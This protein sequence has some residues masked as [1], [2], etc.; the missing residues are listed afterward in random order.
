MASDHDLHE[1]DLERLLPTALRDGLSP[2]PDPSTLAAGGLAVAGHVAACERCQAVVFA[3]MAPSVPPPEPGRWRA[4]LARGRTVFRARPSDLLHIVIRLIDDAL[5][6]VH[7]TGAAPAAASVRS[8]ESAG[9]FVSQQV[10][11]WDVHTHT[12]YSRGGDFAILLDMTLHDADMRDP[13]VGRRGAGLSWGEPRV[14]LL[15]G[16]RELASHVAQR[17]RVLLAGVRPGT[18]RLQLAAGDRAIGG[19][20]VD[21]QTV[22]LQT[23]D[24]QT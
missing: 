8:A 20:T 7:T 24:L 11:A 14:T 6:L 5:E 3:A 22:D 12:S 1:R 15:R 18:Y 16:E 23:V 9:V 17:G 2:C 21:L 4:L 13:G 10:G 19:I